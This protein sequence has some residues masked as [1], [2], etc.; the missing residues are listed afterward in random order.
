PNRPNDQEKMLTF[1]EDNGIPSQVYQ[2][3][4]D[5]S[6]RTISKKLLGHERSWMEVWATN[7][8]VESK[9]LLP[10]GTT[11]RYWPAD[12][13]AVGG[14]EAVKPGADEPEVLGDDEP[15][16]ATALPPVNEPAPPPV[17]E[18]EATPSIPPSA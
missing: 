4:P 7:P 3:G 17:V 15:E 13:I 16:M 18:P 2:S 10:E 11:L 5:E 14:P 12:A 8:S 6:I 9:W 1:Y